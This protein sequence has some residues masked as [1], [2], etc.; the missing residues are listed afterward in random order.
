MLSGQPITDLISSNLMDSGTLIKMERMRRKMSQSDL[1]KRV[2]ISQP[3]IKKIEAGETTK[4][5]YL[6]RIAQ[7][8]D[9]PLSKLDPSLSQNGSVSVNHISTPA[10]TSSAPELHT[11]PGERLMGPV[12]LPVYSMVQG[13]RGALVLSSEAF[14]TVSRPHNLVGIRDSYGVLVTGDS[15]AKE[16]RDGDIAYVNPHLRPREGDACIFQSHRDDGTV[17]AVIKYLARSPE[18]SDT[19]WYVEQSNPPKKF[20][21]KKS[22]WQICHVA[23][24]KQSGR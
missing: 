6:P 16:Y 5:K 9:L 8:L 20:T 23:V 12:D 19:L 2:G 10:R 22:E 14:T 1:A 18:A 21:L 7:E 15:M 3:A 24:G 11:F 17:E 4:S 13:G